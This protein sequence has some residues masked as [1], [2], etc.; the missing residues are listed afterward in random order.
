M[1]HG[2]D[3]KLILGASVDFVI[4]NRQGK[5]VASQIKVLPHGTVSFDMIGEDEYKGVIQ[6]PVIR[7]FTHGRGKVVSVCVVVTTVTMVTFSARLLRGRSYIS[8]AWEGNNVTI[9]FTPLPLLSLS[10]LS[11]S[12]LLSYKE[13]DQDGSYTMCA[14]DIVKF[15]I[16][17]DKRDGSSRATKVILIKLIE[18]QDKNNKRERVSY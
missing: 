5:D 12:P 8:Q 3:T 4:Q 17:T 9:Y 7:S 14:G 15:K 11:L 13:R 18:E 6:S 10:P 2:E 16:A 1:D